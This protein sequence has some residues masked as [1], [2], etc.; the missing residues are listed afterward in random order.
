M[1]FFPILFLEFLQHFLP[2]SHK[3]DPLPLFY[4]I[5]LIIITLLLLLDLFQYL[6]YPFFLLLFRPP[7]VLIKRVKHP[8]NFFPLFDDFVVLLEGGK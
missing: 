4:F 7:A 2:L 6:F 5:I 8:P 3:A 1:K